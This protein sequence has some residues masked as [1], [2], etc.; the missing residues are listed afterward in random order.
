MTNGAHQCHKSIEWEEKPFY[1]ASHI[2]CNK[3]AI[4]G[5]LVS[6]DELVAQQS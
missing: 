1:A 5:Q 4:A 2:L 6:T 3:D